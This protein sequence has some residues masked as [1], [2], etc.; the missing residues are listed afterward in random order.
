MNDNFDI[1][2]FALEYPSNDPISKRLTFAGVLRRYLLENPNGP[3]ISRRWL[4]ES[5]FNQNMSAYRNRIL[6]KIGKY[7]AMEDF[8]ETDF[9]KVLERLAAEG[10][11]EEKTINDYRR[12][13][14]VVY[15]AG[16][17]NGLYEDRLMWD[18]RD[19]V[20][21]DDESDTDAINKKAFIELTRKSLSIEEEKKLLE[22]FKNLDPALVDGDYIGLILMFF[23]GLRNNEAA[24][25]DYGAVVEIQ[26]EGTH[27]PCVYIAK[28][29]ELGSNRTKLG[30]KTSNAPRV[31]PI[32]DFL[33]DFLMR[34]KEFI[35]GKIRSGEI[36][37]FDKSKIDIDRL[38]VVCHG[39]NYLK[40]SSSQG[41][42]DSANQLFSELGIGIR[43]VSAA[44]IGIMNE[45][46]SY[47]HELIAE[48]DITA[49]IF[50]RNTA[51]H[52]YALGL[53]AGQ[54]QYLIGHEIESSEEYRNL[55]TNP[56][57][58]YNIYNILKEHPFYDFFDDDAELGHKY[59]RYTTKNL[60]KPIHVRIVTF[61]PRTR[62]SLRITR[63]SG[64]QLT[65]TP[66][67]FPSG[68]YPR[69][70]NV[71]KRVR[72]AYMPKRVVGEEQVFK[73]KGI[74]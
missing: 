9:E 61:E 4:S 17:E 12:L 52:L 62:L 55:F 42:T 65:Q 67:S 71:R 39:C 53:S 66:Y 34:R 2:H 48:K 8:E 43:E 26:L 7:K 29:T 57:L 40:R 10:E 15:R 64:V 70:A 73:S 38:P 19:K 22:W 32:F 28:T 20:G 50:R 74:I 27:F 60:K 13:I 44:V 45:Q 72:K 37:S 63:G 56:D 21:I 68:A 35:Q 11:Y 36:T 30:G 51:T 46:M 5:Y 18:L 69:T 25:L 6:P 14:W 49:Y 47:P 3:A 31:I 41:I 59:Y 1:A 54:C 24:G 58:L 16:V 33:Y 23:L